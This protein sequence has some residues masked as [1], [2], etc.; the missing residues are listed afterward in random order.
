M[1]IRFEW[2]IVQS[3]LIGKEL[4][5]LIRRYHNAQGIYKMLLIHELEEKYY[6][7]N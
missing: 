7:L 3:N 4:E 6:Q 1:E 2:L 5:A